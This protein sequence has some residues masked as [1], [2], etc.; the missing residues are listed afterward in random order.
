MAARSVVLCMG[1][2]P[3]IIKMAPVHRAL[4]ASRVPTLV[5]HTGQHDQMA[6]PLYEFFGMRPDHVL[7]LER[8]SD[9]LAHLTAVLVE[10]LHGALTGMRPAAVLVQGDTTSALVG[11]LTSFYLRVPVGHIE[12][13]LRTFDIQDPFP[14]E[15]NRQLIGRLARWHF[16]PTRIAAANLRRE[17]IA[18]MTIHPTGN[19]IVDATH[20]GVDYLKALPDAATAVLPPGLATLPAAV[21]HQRIVLVT[22]HRRENWGHGIESIA[23]G[24]RRLLESQSGLVVVWP[25][26]GNPLVKEV[27]ERVFEGLVCGQGSRLLLTDPL[28][29]P[30]LLWVM[31]RSWLILS[32]SGG[33]QEEAVSAR[34]PILVLRETTERPELIAAGAG[35]LV[36]TDADR[37]CREFLALQHDRDLYER[38]RKARNPFGD[39]HAAARIVDVLLRDL[40]A[41]RPAPAPALAPAPVAAVETAEA[42]MS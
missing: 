13:G 30:A 22:A 14:E 42:G 6:W 31:S 19:T 29:Y 37:L 20:W 9:S 25:V 40:P 35:K 26:H 34:V 12:A 8:K 38:M 27:V 4:R 16:P 15:A 36:G 18:P 24:V 1:T 39:G 28:N 33:I 10:Q 11:A 41:L 3:E 2:R 17:G 5:L 23:R 32:D 7:P 21:G